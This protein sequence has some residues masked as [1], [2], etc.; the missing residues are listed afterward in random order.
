MRYE[1]NLERQLYRALN[2]LE[3]LQRLRKGE[4][5]PPPVVVQVSQ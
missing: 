1:A 5:V 3:R 2:Q 4:S